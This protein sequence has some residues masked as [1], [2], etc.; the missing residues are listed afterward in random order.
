MT[1]QHMLDIETLDTQA[2]TIVVS[3]GVV[4]FDP[5]NFGIRG[6]YYTVLEMGEQKYRGRTE[7]EDTKAWWTAQP[8]DACAVFTAPR[9]EVEAA[10]TTLAAFLEGTSGVWGNGADF[11]NV[12]LGSLFRTFGMK[13]P[14]SFGKNR[15]FRTVKNIL[16][17]D[18]YKRPERIGVHHNALDDA[19]SQLFELEAICRA[20]NIR[21]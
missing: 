3:I 12:I 9:E 21:F 15:C 5:I 17:P 8:E 6:S 10:L 13:A 1:I 7:S 14:W 19:A 20:L 4:A 18:D 16:M 11:D 2:S